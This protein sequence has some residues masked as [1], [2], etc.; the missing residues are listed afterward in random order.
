MAVSLKHTKKQ[1]RIIESVR[2]IISA[3]GI[4]K[5]TIHEIA[6]DLGVTDGALYRH[7]KSKKE[8]ISLLI[9]DIEKTLLA[10]IAE[11]AGKSKEPRQKIRDIFLSHLSYAEQRKGFTFIIINETLNI[12]DKSLQKKMFGVIQKYLKVIEE[13]FRGG[14]GS[15]GFRKGIDASSAS[16]VFFGTVQSIVTLWALS[17]YKYPLGKAGL[18]KILGIYEKGIAA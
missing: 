14:N 11:A 8:I 17:G 7:F 9:D 4:E 16:I 18:D 15:T 5:L 13:I 12:R 2:R 6:K 1:I 10:S 3:K